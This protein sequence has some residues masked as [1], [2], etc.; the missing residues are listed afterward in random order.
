M[1]NVNSDNRIKNYH[2]E[3]RAIC[4]GHIKDHNFTFISTLTKTLKLLSFTC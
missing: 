1:F 4:I 2:V 3:C